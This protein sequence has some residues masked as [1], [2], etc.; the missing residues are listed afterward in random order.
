MSILG[1]LVVFLGPNLD[2]EIAP[3]PGLDPAPLP[4]LESADPLLE[5][6]EASLPFDRDRD[7]SSRPFLTLKVDFFCGTAKF[8]IF[9]FN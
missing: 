7:R 6:E 9:K 3:L 4:G 5:I 1:G 8:S 2:A